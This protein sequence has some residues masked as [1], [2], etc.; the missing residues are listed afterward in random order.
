MLI[1]QALSYIGT[2]ALLL[3]A[4]GLP[5]MICVEVLFGLCTA[6]DVGYYSYLYAIVSKE[7]YKKVASFTRAS[8]LGGKFV[9]Y[10]A[11]QLLVSFDLM[12]YFQLNIISFS[13]VIVAFVIAVVLPRASYSEIFHR[14]KAENGVV[15]GSKDQYPAEKAKTKSCHEQLKAGFIFM[16]KEVKN[17]YSSKTVVIWSLWWALASCG[18]FQVQNYIQNL[19]EVVSPHK[20][21]G[22]IYN[23]AVEAVGTLVCKLLETFCAVTDYLSCF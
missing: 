20:T 12:D 21:S 18:S 23:G 7:H 13:S 14:P 2:W 1:V 11:G 4:K 17:N 16:W 15:V 19:W 6:A 9:A 10:L 8:I 22:T 5:A 3:W